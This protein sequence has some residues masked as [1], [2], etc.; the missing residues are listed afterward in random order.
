MNQIAFTKSHQALF[1]FYRVFAFVIFLLLAFACASQKAP[2]LKPKSDAQLHYELTPLLEQH[3]TRVQVDLYFH[4]NERGQSELLLPSTWGNGK[5]LAK[6]IESVQVLEKNITLTHLNVQNRIRVTYPPKTPRVAIR[7]IYKLPQ[8][9]Q[10]FRNSSEL[11]PFG[12]HEFIHLIGETFLIHPDWHPHTKRPVLVKWLLPAEWQGFT[13]LSAS[14][15]RLS[16]IDLK[17]LRQS[18]FVAGALF[19][20]HLPN[21]SAVLVAPQNVG[22]SAPIINGIQKVLHNANQFYTA[23]NAS[24]LLISLFPI[25]TRCCDYKG[26]SLHNALTLMLPKNLMPNTNLWHL[27][28]HELLHRWNGQVLKRKVNDEQLIWFNEGVTDFLARKINYESGLITLKDYVTGLNRALWRWQHTKPNQTRLSHNDHMMLRY[29]KG[30]LLSLQIDEIITS[31]TKNKHSWLQTLKDMT[32]MPAQEVSKEQLHELILKNLK[33]K[34]SREALAKIQ[35]LLEH[36]NTQ[37]PQNI[38]ECIRLFKDQGILVYKYKNG[39]CG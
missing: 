32:Q 7:Y 27:L 36:K 31:D 24:P 3:Q 34:L 8:P 17:T 4:G 2:S 33:T 39:I 12:N 6:K 15:A 26:L 19:I 5:G 22:L 9:P 18:V 16:S 38:G 11:R 35:E 21:E 10:D 20:K 30:E 28:S 14:Q 23:Q 1:T 29:A 13:S 37:P 25:G